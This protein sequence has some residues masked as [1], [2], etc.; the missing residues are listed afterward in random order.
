MNFDTAMT[1]RARRSVNMF[2]AELQLQLGVKPRND[3]LKCMSA[4]RLYGG[5]L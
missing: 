3:C 5:R 1:V 4:R 2:I